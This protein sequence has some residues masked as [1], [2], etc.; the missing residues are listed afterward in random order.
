MSV[1]RIFRSSSFLL[2]PFLKQTQARARVSLFLSCIPAAIS[3]NLSLDLGLIIIIF[4]IVSKPAS[5]LQRHGDS[6]QIQALRL[7]SSGH[8]HPR[9]DSIR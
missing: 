1:L 4:I 6:S 8:E 9:V 2:E 7:H 5:R 3:S